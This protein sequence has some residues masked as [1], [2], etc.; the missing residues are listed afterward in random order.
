MRRILSSCFALTVAVG[1]LAIPTPAQAQY[2]QHQAAEGSHVWGQDGWCY[3]VQRGRLVRT[4]YQ[5]VFPNPMNRTV[6]DIYQNGQFV[7]RVG[8]PSRPASASRQ[9]NAEVQLQSLVNQLNQ[10]VAVARTQA[11]AAVPQRVGMPNCPAVTGPF[12]QHNVRVN[13]PMAAHCM[14]P[15]EKR[16][17]N[18]MVVDTLTN[19]TIRTQRV[20]CENARDSQAYVH[21]YRGRDG[22]MVYRLRDGSE[23]RQGGT[24]NSGWYWGATGP[25][26][27]V[28]R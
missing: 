12:M 20:R 2:G 10:Q 21:S 24:L 19:E 6:F 8:A 28:C 11:P 14:T 25:Q 5:R 22:V 4:S 7:R 23:H 18:K 16:W 3:V 17:N 13:I 27:S 9:A 26:L 15:E 1:G